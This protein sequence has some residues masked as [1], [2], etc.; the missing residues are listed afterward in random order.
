ML[1]SLDLSAAFDTIGHTILLSLQQT[2]FGISGP[3]LAWLHSYLDVRSQFV[4]IGCSMSPVTL[5]AMDVPEG[6]VLGDMLFPY[7]SHPLHILSVH[8]ASCSS[9]TLT[10]LTFWSPYPKTITI[11]QSPNSSFVSQ[12]SIPS[13]CYNGLAL[14]PD[15]SCLALPRSHV[16]FQLPLLS[17]L[18]EPL[19]RFPIRSGF[20]ALP[21][22]VDSHLMHTSLFSLLTS[23]F[24]HICALHHIRPNLILDC[25]KKIAC[26]PSSAVASITPTRPSWR[27]RLRTFL[28]FNVCKARSL[29][30]SHVNGDAS[31]TPRLCKSFIG[32]LSRGT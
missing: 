16:L 12:P 23:C 10:T 31:A 13:F 5:C 32:F 2:S 17:K 19:S 26:S 8:M 27:S 11:L 3:A 18:L 6:S 25:S 1:I 29:A 24:Y 14:N 28:G 30:L 4:R 7:S 15:K 22:T 21:L 20:L 9:S